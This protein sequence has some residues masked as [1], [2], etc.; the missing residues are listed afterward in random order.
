MTGHGF[1]MSVYVLTL[2]QPSDRPPEV[3]TLSS[4]PCTEVG[5]LAD[6]DE[7][8]ARWHASRQS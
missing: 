4:P 5:T 1:G 3:D 2:R 6:Q 7:F 8:Q